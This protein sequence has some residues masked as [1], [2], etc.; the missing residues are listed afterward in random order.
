MLARCWWPGTP[1]LLARKGNAFARM[2]ACC[3]TRSLTLSAIMNKFPSQPALCL[4]AN[5]SAHYHSIR[6]RG[7]WRE[8]NGPCDCYQLK[9]VETALGAAL[10]S[11]FVA[12]WSLIVPCVQRLQ[13]CGILGLHVLSLD[14]IDSEA[15]QLC[16]AIDDWK[17]AVRIDGLSGRRPSSASSVS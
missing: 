11:E 14:T 15:A 5:H 9:L 16:G 17:L 3:G 8:Y 6:Y 12:D 7:Q 1:S 13:L 4:P 2:S 10:T